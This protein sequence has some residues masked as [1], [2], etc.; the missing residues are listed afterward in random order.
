MEDGSI[1]EY[2]SGLPL[3]I[4]FSSE[5]LRTLSRRLFGCIPVSEKENLRLDETGVSRDPCK[6]DENRTQ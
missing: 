1:G 6:D 5:D 2:V 3:W 4:L